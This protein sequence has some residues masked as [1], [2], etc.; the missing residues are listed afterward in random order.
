MKVAVS[1]VGDSLEAPVDPRFGRCPYFVIV[2]TDTMA[3][4]AISNASAGAVSG[5]GTLA[6]QAVAAKGVQAVITGNVGPNAFQVLSSAG[7]KVITGASGTVREAVERFKNGQLQE[8]TAP[9][10]AR[11]MGVG[12]GR[13][14][15]VG[16]GRGMGGFLTAPFHQASTSTTPISRE[17][18]VSTLAE[19]VR[20][21]QQE[22]ER[23]KKRLDELKGS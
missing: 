13:G 20:S 1:A 14:M 8:A 9:A 18:E 22:I 17:Q 19:Q 11:G 4:E 21:L 6:A 15:G 23:I 7:I 10:Y 12:M 16:R 5:A 2:D 3:F